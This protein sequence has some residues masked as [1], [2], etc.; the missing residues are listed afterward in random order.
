MPYRDP[1]RKRENAKIWREKNKEEIKIQRHGYYLANKEEILEK[2][3]EYA[4]NNP[5]KVKGYKKK[6]RINN[7]ETHNSDSYARYLNRLFFIDAIKQKSNGCSICGFKD[8]R[9]LDFHHR[10][11][12]EKLFNISNYLNQHGI[13]QQE[14]LNEIKK[15]DILCKNCHAI[16]HRKNI[17]HEL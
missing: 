6:H 5:D 16:L 2:V 1:I 10:V 13:S 14:V 17:T 7:R 15:C 4:E 9:A 11:P 3:K 12:E 8:Y